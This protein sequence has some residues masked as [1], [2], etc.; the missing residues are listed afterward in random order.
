MRGGG[1]FGVRVRGRR[2][3]GKGNG[4]DF[5]FAGREGKGRKLLQSKNEC[6]RGLLDGVRTVFILLVLG[7]LNFFSHYTI[8]LRRHL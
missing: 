7:S 8:L 4:G 2:G 5:D 1:D 3:G 6:F